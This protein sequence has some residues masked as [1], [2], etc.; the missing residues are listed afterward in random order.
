M[1]VNIIIPTFKRDRI[2]KST[3]D[4]FIRV[5]EGYDYHIYVVN[6]NDYDLSMNLQRLTVLKGVENG[7]THARNLAVEQMRLC[8]WV[9]F[10][11][12]DLYIYDDLPLRSLREYSKSNLGLVNF[13]TRLRSDR[14]LIC[15]KDTRFNN[16]RSYNSIHISGGN[17]ICAYKLAKE[18]KWDINFKG[19]SY[20]EDLAFGLEIIN[21]GKFI[22]M[23]EPEIIVRH[24]GENREITKL[25]LKKQLSGLIYLSKKYSMKLFRPITFFLKV[26]YYT[27]FSFFTFI[28]LYLNLRSK[29][30]T[31]V[32]TFSNDLDSS[33]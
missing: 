12:D 22:T 25:F 17:M 19:Y 15:K 2:L 32:V 3:I 26:L 14:R 24:F 27:P 13:S 31:E 5:L 6:N 11:D 18:I 33:Q 16:S 28:V 10:A 21:S 30:A 29:T 7:P 20:G 4:S 1:K 23:F 9:W 8:D